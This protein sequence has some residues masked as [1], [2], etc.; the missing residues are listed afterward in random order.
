MLR[1]RL[2]VLATL[3]ALAAPWVAPCL[4]AAP[5]GHAQMPCCKAKAGGPSVRPC[6]TPANQQPLAPAQT[7]ANTAAAGAASAIAPVPVPAFLSR[8]HI[9]AAPIVPLQIQLRSTV[10]L[11]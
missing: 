4:T 1:L 7:A 8:M 2:A 5:S 10:L 6:C 9:P 3:M 11:I